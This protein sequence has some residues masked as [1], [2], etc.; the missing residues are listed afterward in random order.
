[1]IQEAER[2]GDLNALPPHGTTLEEIGDLSLKGLSQA[3]A[4]YNVPK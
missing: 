3:V 2:A 1:L 4:V